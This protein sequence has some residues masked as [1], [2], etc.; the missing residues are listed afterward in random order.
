MGFLVSLVLGGRCM[1][2]SESHLGAVLG[3]S[4]ISDNSDDSF[5]CPLEREL[6]FFVHARGLPLKL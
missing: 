1:V 2:P 3:D 4:T 6:R 5:S